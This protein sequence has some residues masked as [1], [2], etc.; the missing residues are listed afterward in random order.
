MKWLFGIILIIVQAFI[1]GLIFPL[2]FLRAMNDEDDSLTFYIGL[3]LC[4]LAYGAVALVC[5]TL[6][7]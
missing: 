5:A 1:V 3:L 7:P 6:I 2:V 4:V